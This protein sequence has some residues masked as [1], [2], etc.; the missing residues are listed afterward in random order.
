MQSKIVIAALLF[1]Q[2]TVFCM[3]TRVSKRNFDSEELVVDETKR[4]RSADNHE[5]LNYQDLPLIYFAGSLPS[6]VEE[7]GRIALAQSY[8]QQERFWDIQVPDIFV[9]EDMQLFR[10]L[11]L[12]LKNGVRSFYLKNQPGLLDFRVPIEIESLINIT[13]FKYTQNK[14]CQYLL[15]I[16]P[17]YKASVIN[18]FKT[19]SKNPAFIL[20]LLNKHG[21]SI[22]R[23]CRADMIDNLYTSGLLQNKR[24]GFKEFSNSEE[25]FC[26]QWSCAVCLMSPEPQDFPIAVTKRTVCGHIFCQTCIVSM[27]KN[28]V[29]CALCRNSIDGFSLES[30]KIFS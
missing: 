30:G 26:G 18:L 4:L 11:F 12:H 19:K 23:R 15:K 3:E 13:I 25:Y 8:M 24:V 28:N 2:A 27:L 1:S 14:Y 6:M 10:L 29:D 20:N 17:G 22:T 5:V 9:I 7:S 21:V 16:V